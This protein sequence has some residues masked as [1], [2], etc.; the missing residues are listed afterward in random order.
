MKYTGRIIITLVGIG[1]VSI[2]RMYGILY[3]NVP[4]NQ[5]PLVGLF[6]VLVLWTLGSPYD[7]LKFLSERDV[8]TKLYNRRY[9]QKAFPKL[10]TLAARKQEKLI[11]YFIDVD[12]FKLINDTHGHEI[13]DQVLQRIASVLTRHSSK[14]DLVVRW[15]GDEF[16]ILSPNTDDYSKASMISSIQNE[17]MLSSQELNFSI[18]VSIGSAIYPD[19]AQSLDGILHVADQDM[20]ALKLGAS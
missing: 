16:L 15:A 2:V 20:Y 18:S 9:M 3:Y 7:K 13:G 1:L 4:P 6:V 19:Q 14:R 5:F 8:L 17:L 10:F 12:N 11:L